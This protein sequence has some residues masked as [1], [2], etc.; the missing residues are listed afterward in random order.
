MASPV[1]LPGRTALLL[2]PSPPGQEGMLSHLLQMQ[3]AAYKGL[4]RRGS[5]AGQSCSLGSAGL[6]TEC[7]SAA[8]LFPKQPRL[9]QKLSR[10]RE[11]SRAL[12][13]VWLCVCPLLSVRLSHPRSLFPCGHHNWQG[14]GSNSAAGPG[15]PVLTEPCHLDQQ[16]ESIWETKP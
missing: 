15:Q 12:Q 4:S 3:L 14:R 8:P 7:R 2:V 11:H 1:S 6:P 16:A 10:A 5:V 9:S 13:G